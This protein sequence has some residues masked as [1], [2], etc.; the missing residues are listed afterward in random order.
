VNA[1][2]LER[3]D[4][5]LHVDDGRNY[6]LTTTRRYDVLTADIIQP[7]HAGAG[8]LYSVEYFQLARKVLAP[9]G[10]MLQWI[11]TR[12]ATQYKLI[13]RTFM[14]VFPHATAWASGTLFV[15]RASPLKLDPAA[16][17]GKLEDAGTRRALGLVDI[18]SVESLRGLYSA[19]PKALRRF[20]WVRGLF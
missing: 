1:G 8:S 9:G 2:V 18:T 5:Q 13:A 16:F 6:L 7:V 20:V 12:P 17:A 14:Q 15:G 3:P 19:G 4:V 10:L 11:G